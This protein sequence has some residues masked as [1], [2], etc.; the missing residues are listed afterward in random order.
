MVRS[1]GA[2]CRSLVVHSQLSP[3][4]VKKLCSMEDGIVSP[5]NKPNRD[6]GP[7]FK[8]LDSKN[9]SNNV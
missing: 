9:V 8:I 1:F 2:I 5:L 3:I 6:V 7:K 4:S